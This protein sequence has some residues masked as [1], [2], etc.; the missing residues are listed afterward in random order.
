MTQH[1]TAQ[2]H[3][4]VEGSTPTSAAPPLTGAACY[5]VRRRATWT[6]QSVS[7]STCKQVARA[8][9]TLWQLALCGHTTTLLT[10]CSLG[11]PLVNFAS[12]PA[13]VMHPQPCFPHNPTSSTPHVCSAP[14]LLH[15]ASIQLLW[16]SACILHPTSRP[17]HGG[18]HAAA[19]SSRLLHVNVPPEPDGTVGCH[20]SQTLNINLHTAMQVREVG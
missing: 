6:I 10:S 16:Q 11:M 19:C 9:T 1:K 7:G 3:C 18:Q 2:P 20:V 5:A 13:F 17:P 4:R 15:R 14:R 8:T 12:Q